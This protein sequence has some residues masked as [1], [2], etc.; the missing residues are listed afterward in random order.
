[1]CL[2]EHADA[3]LAAREDLEPCIEGRELYEQ[4]ANLGHVSALL[5]LGV[6]KQQDT[7]QYVKVAASL[8]IEEDRAVAREHYAAVAQLGFPV[9]MHNLARMHKFG[10]VSCDA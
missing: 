7:D 2:Y 5:K 10:Q 8:G 3:L 4:S 1:M 6:C 9:G